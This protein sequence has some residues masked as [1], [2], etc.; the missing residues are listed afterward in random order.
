VLTFALARLS[1]LSRVK[2]KHTTTGLGRVT[3]PKAIGSGRTYVTNPN[4]VPFLG[5]PL[6]TGCGWGDAQKYVSNFQVTRI[7]SVERGVCPIA[8]VCTVLFYCPDV[9][10]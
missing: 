1:C 8:A 9:T 3:G 7:R 6:S 5:C 4:T 2:N 10:P